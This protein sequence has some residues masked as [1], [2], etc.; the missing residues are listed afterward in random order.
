MNEPRCCPRIL[1][2]E[3]D[4]DQ[5][6]LVCEALGIYYQDE[7]GTNITAVA[8]AQQA[9]AQPLVKFDV[10]L[11]GDHPSDNSGLQLLND[12]RS[13]ADLPV[14][15]VT[16]KS[17]SAI[18]VEA[19]QNGAQD[20]I[21]KLGDY[22][23]A[24]PILIDKSIHT[25]QTK[26][27]NDRLHRELKFMVSQLRTKNIQLEESLDQLKLMATTDHLTDLANRRHFAQV[28][29]RYFSEAKRYGFDLT[30]C[31]CDL[32][33]YKR[34]NDTL[35]HQAG[36]KLLVTA[37]RIIT[38]SLR[39]SDVA[40]RYGGDELVLLPSHTPLDRGMVVGD[41]IRRELAEACQDYA[42]HGLP[43][44]ISVGVASVEANKPINADELVMMADKAL[45]L[46]KDQGKDCIRSFGLVKAER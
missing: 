27:D 10:V 11:L 23:F 32:D 13:R 45:Y 43:V 41:R 1:I 28:L 18:A 44:T 3:N 22:L 33:D 26:I 21:V 12:I 29:E 42:D 39:N 38:S 20:F 16:D 25:H 5:R 4:Q 37:A 35:G 15:F 24:L 36:D 34:L 31:M 9:L 7:N 19:I 46:A 6:Q 40:A 17:D 2:V 30:C 14:I 8:N